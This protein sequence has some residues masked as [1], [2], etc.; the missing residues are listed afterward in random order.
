MAR[1]PNCRTRRFVR[2][3]SAACAVRLGRPP[4]ASGNAIGFTHKLLNLC[5][6]FLDTAPGVDDRARAP[7]R[8]GRGR[9]AGF[10]LLHGRHVIVSRHIVTML[11]HL[12]VGT[13]SRLGQEAQNGSVRSRHTAHANCTRIRKNIHA[14]PTR[15]ATLAPILHW[16]EKH[17]HY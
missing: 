14:T 15:Y 12:V 1:L 3:I 13:A 6:L 8:Q 7:T 5:D 11:G 2:R 9:P 10:P 16:R 17:P 4:V